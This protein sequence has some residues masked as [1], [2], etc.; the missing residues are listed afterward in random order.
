ML[1]SN[2]ILRIFLTIDENLHKMVNDTES[3]ECGKSNNSTVFLLGSS[4]MAPRSAGG[5][6]RVVPS[7]KVSGPRGTFS[8]LAPTFSHSETSQSA[9]LNT[10]GRRFA[11]P[12]T[13]AQQRLQPVRH[14]NGTDTW[15]WRTW[16][17]CNSLSQ[18]I[19][20]VV[21]VCINVFFPGHHCVSSSNRCMWKSSC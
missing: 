3:W 15:R 14:N 16:G 18:A 17:N 2:C 20:K 6:S 21:L 7:C 4:P 12:E 1:H 9:I 11:S 5:R 8:S 10:S 19:D 13:T